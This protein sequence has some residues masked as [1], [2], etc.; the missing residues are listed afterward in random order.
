M[1]Q[2]RPK[3]AKIR[4]TRNAKFAKF[5]ARGLNFSIFNFYEGLPKRHQDLILFIVA[6]NKRKLPNIAILIYIFLEVI[7]E[8]YNI[9]VTNFCLALFCLNL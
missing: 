4:Y 3:L 8:L 1:G 2:N 7:E 5:G 9:T 6:D